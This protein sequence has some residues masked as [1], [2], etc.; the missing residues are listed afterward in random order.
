M[1][2]E[3]CPGILVAQVEQTAFFPAVYPF[4]M[5]FGQPGVGSH[6]FR[7][8]PDNNIH[9]LGVGVVGDGPQT[10]REPILV[11]FPGTR[12]GPA[13]LV[14]I[15]PGIHPPVR[16]TSFGSLRWLRPF[17]RRCASCSRTNRARA[18]CRSAWVRCGPASSAARCSDHE[19]SRWSRTGVQSGACGFLPQ[20]AVSGK[21]TP[22]QR[23]R[24][25]PPPHPASRATTIAPASRRRR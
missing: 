7:L 6:P 9:V 24:V 1:I 10:A 19:S 17:P 12:V 2:Y 13:G 11:H 15:P 4:R 22:G 23:E 5:V 8:E 14:V 20:G 18:T 16:C 25:A 3:P 21:S